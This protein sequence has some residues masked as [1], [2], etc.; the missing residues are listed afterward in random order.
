MPTQIRGD[1]I[2]SET[3]TSDNILNDSITSEDIAAGTIVA[4]DL[5]LSLLGQFYKVKVN[6]GDSTADFLANKLTA[7]EGITLSTGSTITI[8]SSGGAGG[9][10]FGASGA[11]N[12]VPLAADFPVT[13]LGSG[14]VTDSTS[15]L[16]FVANGHGPTSV[17]KSTRFTNHIYMVASVLRVVLLASLYNGT[18]SKIHFN[19]KHNI[20]NMITLQ[21]EIRTILLDMLAGVHIGKLR[22]LDLT[23]YFPPLLLVRLAHMLQSIQ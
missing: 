8:S 17:L 6:S 14:S 1:Q 13:V 20:N 11:I 5:A 18:C 3:I 7:G 12:K 23:S 10:S 16:L 2:Q 4:S 15:G 19:L 21:Q 22:I 9:T